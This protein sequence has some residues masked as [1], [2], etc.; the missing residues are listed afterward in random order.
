M[1][2]TPTRCLRCGKLLR[3][4]FDEI[5]YLRET[6]HKTAEE[7]IKEKYSKLF[8]QCPICVTALMNCT[9]NTRVQKY[10]TSQIRISPT[11]S[12]ACFHYPSKK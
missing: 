4:I 2:S 3:A 10:F 9:D 7:I 5:N 1:A 6:E 11:P 12:E 8:E